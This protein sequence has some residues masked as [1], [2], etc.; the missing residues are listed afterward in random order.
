[1][2][3]EKFR[4]KNVKCGGCVNTIRQGLMALAGVAAVDV[5]IQSGEVTVEGEAIDRSVVAQRLGELGYPEGK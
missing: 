1:M 4:V 5:A 2:Q 3:T